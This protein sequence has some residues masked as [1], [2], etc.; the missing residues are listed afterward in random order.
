M[1][2]D[3]FAHAVAALLPKFPTESTNKLLQAALSQGR[4]S[5]LQALTTVAELSKFIADVS[6]LLLRNLSQ[7]CDDV[8]AW[9]SGFDCCRQ[10]KRC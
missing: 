8:A 1:V 6:R 7:Y 9:T 10:P 3:G 2:T 4:L 5:V